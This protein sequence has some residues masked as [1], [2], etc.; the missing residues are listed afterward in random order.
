MKWC[1]E[2]ECETYESLPP[3]FYKRDN[4]VSWWTSATLPKKGSFRD[5]RDMPTDLSGVLKLAYS[6]A[7]RR[8]VPSS[9]SIVGKIAEK[10]AFSGMTVTLKVRS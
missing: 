3:I 2:S 8:I 6:N 1:E 5:F 4:S 10:P 7:I 9:T